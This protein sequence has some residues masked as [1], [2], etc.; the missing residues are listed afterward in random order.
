MIYLLT[1]N[2]HQEILKKKKGLISILQKKQPDAAYIKI[3]IEDATEELFTTLLETQGLF[4]KKNIVSLGQI[5]EQDEVWSLFKKRLKEF[6][7]S[8]HVFV[9]SEVYEH[10]L[11]PLRKKI[12]LIKKVAQKT[13]EVERKSGGEKETEN[14]NFFIF[15]ETFFIKN[16]KDVWVD[17]QKIRS[18]VPDGDIPVNMLLWQTR[19]VL[20]VANSKSVAESGLKPF[21][22]NKAKS[23]LEKQ[24]VE[25]IKDVLVHLTRVA[26]EMRMDKKKGYNLLEEFILSQ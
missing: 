26:Q 13:I 18:E 6:S 4:L 3:V 15:A 19:A 24:G 20:Q 23:I 10:P 11:A 22:Y 2:N 1:G 14:P 5:C 16:K 17:F 21:V 25:K 9:W 7:E 12:D 8:E